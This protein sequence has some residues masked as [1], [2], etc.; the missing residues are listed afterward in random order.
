MA[1]GSGQ[2]VTNWAA[3]QPYRLEIGTWANRGL[4]GWVQQSS[5]FQTKFTT[6]C[7]LLQALHK[8]HHSVVCCTNTW[9]ASLFRVW[10]LHILQAIHSTLHTCMQPLA[11]HRQAYFFLQWSVT[12]SYPVGNWIWPTSYQ[13][14]ST[15]SPTK[16]CCRSL[17]LNMQAG[18]QLQGWDTRTASQGEQVSTL[19]AVRLSTVPLA[20]L[21][22]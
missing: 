16:G 14:G 3:P 6:G 13:L 4:G 10:C 21:A 9:A 7:S 8:P 17:G 12:H 15:T 1:I 11:W 18:A 22:R 19:R 2:T 5:P 20:R